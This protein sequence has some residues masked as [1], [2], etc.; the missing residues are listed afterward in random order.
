MV[1]HL[2]L[3][4]RDVHDIISTRMQVREAARRAGM[5]PSD[6]ARISLAT[7]SLME[8]LNS[9]QVSSLASIVI[10]Q[11]NEG[12]DQGMR[13]VFTF[14]SLKEHQALNAVPRNIGWLVDNIEINNQENDKVEIVLTKSIGRR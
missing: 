14:S 6:Q 4:I 2:L 5:V 7:S 1:A 11:K 8:G 10:E 12:G 13:V 9:E 3:N